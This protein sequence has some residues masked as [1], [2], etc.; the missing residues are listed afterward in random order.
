VLFGPKGVVHPNQA[1]DENFSKMTWLSGAHTLQGNTAF[2]LYNVFSTLMVKEYRSSVALAGQLFAD[3]IPY[4]IRESMMKYGWI[5][6]SIYL[7]LLFLTPGPWLLLDRIMAK[8]WEPFPTVTGSGYD[9]ISCVIN[10]TKALSPLRLEVMSHQD[11]DAA[12]KLFRE[13][14]IQTYREYDE[15]T[16]EYL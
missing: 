8:A 12:I 15:F 14:Q 2:L 4:L 10:L 3:F 16:S 9:R 11:C 5:L 6:G 13:L 1:V 7:P